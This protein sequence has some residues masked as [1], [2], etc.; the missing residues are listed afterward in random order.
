MMMLPF[1]LLA[2]SKDDNTPTKANFDNLGISSVTI[3]GKSY[4]VK[5]GGLLDGITDQNI[6]CTGSQYTE[7]TKKAQ[8]EYAIISFSQQTLSCAVQ[9]KYTDVSISVNVESK[10]DIQTCIVQISR[11]GYDEVLIY[12]FVQKTLLQ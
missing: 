11:K 9:S 10:D 5:E 1:V 8:L 3:N 2:C 4:N 12:K 6:V 7:S